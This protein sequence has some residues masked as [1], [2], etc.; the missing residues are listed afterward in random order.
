M[1][2]RLFSQ[3]SRSRLEFVILLLLIAAAIVILRFAIQTFDAAPHIGWDDSLANI[4]VYL[5][6]HGQYGFPLN[7]GSGSYNTAVRLTG[8]YTYG[9]WIFTASAALDFIFG[10]SYG[11]LR[12]IHPLSIL[13]ITFGG[14]FFWRRHAL[15][16]ATFMALS[17]LFIYW[18]IHSPMFRPD[19]FN[20]L[21]MLFALISIQKAC[22]KNAPRDWYFTGLFVGMATTNH[23]ILW[24]MP[25][26]AV[27]IWA[28]YSFQT[29]PPKNVPRQTFIALS[30]G[31]LTSFAIF[32]YAIDFRLGT[33]I[34]FSLGY[35]NVVFVN[36]LT[37]W[38]TVEKHLAHGWPGLEKIIYGA[39]IV[40][41]IVT[42]AVAST[43]H[44]FSALSARHLMRILPGCSAF[45]IFT[46][47]LGLYKSFHLGYTYLNHLLLI[48]ACT[49]IITTLSLLWRHHWPQSGNRLEPF[50]ASLFALAL[51]PIIFLP[52]R[53]FDLPIKMSRLHWINHAKGSIPYQEM[54]KEV[55]GNIPHNSR[56]WGLLQLGL[57]STKRIHYTSTLDAIRL[58]GV[59]TAEQ[60][61]KI[62][63][64]VLIMGAP[65]SQELLCHMLYFGQKETPRTLKQ[66]YDAGV[67]FGSQFF[68]VNTLYPDQA[69]TLSKLV[70][71]PPN[72]I[73]RTYTLSP[74]KDQKKYL[75]PEVAVHQGWDSPWARSV[76]P[77][78]E[79]SFIPTPTPAHF[80]LYCLNKQ[81]APEKHTKNSKK[82]AQA[83]RSQ[84]THLPA[85]TY[86]ISAK[87]NNVDFDHYGALVATSTMHFADFAID[88]GVRMDIAPYTYNARNQTLYLLAKHPGGLLV[89]SQ[90]DDSKNA[91]FSI[92]AVQK[93][94][95]PKPH[96]W[97]ERPF[98]DANSW[99]LNTD[100]R[101]RSIENGRLIVQGDSSHYTLTSA[102]VT[103]TPNRTIIVEPTIYGNPT[104]WMGVRDADSGEWIIQ[105]EWNRTALIFDSRSARRIQLV[106]DSSAKR[107]E[108]IPGKILEKTGLKEVKKYLEDL[109][110][111]RELDGTLKKD[112]GCLTNSP[113]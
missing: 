53:L 34:S 30:A 65:H 47:S 51:I 72:S 5:S 6:E 82:I 2:A 67:Q 23:Y 37:F 109:T 25:L 29:S 97:R 4:P 11:I 107:I 92:T 60:R 33:L 35:S 9:P 3:E 110:H 64:H 68:L 55:V 39:W 61:K 16:A 14:F 86:L 15:S 66:V 45:V 12:L 20:P 10:T 79:H 105:P 19:I 108:L 81:A 52:W 48:W 17:I 111:C 38:Q 42:I 112:P 62:M 76:E 7:P 24:A 88:M 27:G 90:F 96:N 85:G 84:S 103:V 58:S 31:G 49:A 95:Q 77:V 63:P 26:W 100:Q 36:D 57:T 18:R 54:I 106:I 50:F 69:F 40:L 91:N 89:L 73:T 1:R 22:A 46:A 99:Q 8:F 87:V 80:D 32:L 41:T 104:P 93:V 70:S 71:A 113:L 59:Q 75:P 102:P 83:H 56:V 21:L 44:R 28:L 94:L 98:P 43:I 101:N 74:Q 78:Q 13:V